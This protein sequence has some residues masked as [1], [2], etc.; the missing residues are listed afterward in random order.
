MVRPAGDR[1]QL[2]HRGWCRRGRSGLPIVT[3]SAEDVVDL[4]T[5]ARLA[6]GLWWQP[7]DE[8]SVDADRPELRSAAGGVQRR[9]AARQDV[10]E[11]PRVVLRVVSPLGRDVVL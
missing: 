2:C 9:V 5:D 6:L 3:T 8:R 10:G 1:S 7:G 11:E 4:L